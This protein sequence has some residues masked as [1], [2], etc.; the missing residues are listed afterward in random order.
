MPIKVVFCGSN[1][2]LHGKKGVG[3]CHRFTHLLINL[4]S[5]PEPL[6]TT[7]GTKDLHKGYIQYM[8]KYVCMYMYKRWLQVHVFV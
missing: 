4:P 2:L 5:F 3:V 1:L 8:C 7:P 6:A